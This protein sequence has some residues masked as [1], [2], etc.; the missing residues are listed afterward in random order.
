MFSYSFGYALQESVVWSG[1]KS[2]MAPN[3][4]KSTKKSGIFF[5]AKRVLGIDPNYDRR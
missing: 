4:D 1:R 5:R 2:D 3:L